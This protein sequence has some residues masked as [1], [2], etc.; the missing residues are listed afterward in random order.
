MFNMSLKICGSHA[1]LQPVLMFP[2]VNREDG[3]SPMLT[4]GV[5]VTHLFIYRHWRF[6]LLLQ[7]IF[8]GLWEQQAAALAAHS[9]AT[10]VKTPVK[11][12]PTDTAAPPES[13][14]RQF[15]PGRGARSSS[16]SVTEQ[17]IQRSQS[18]QRSVGFPG[19][20]QLSAH[21]TT[22]SHQLVWSYPNLRW[23]SEAQ[24]SKC[25]RRCCSIQTEKSTIFLVFGEFGF[26]ASTW[27]P[28]MIIWL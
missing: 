27:C 3:N 22:W 23:S 4:A 1:G 10:A 14:A 20:L 24:T 26:R 28:M 6:H 5:Q 9:S 2:D 8:F 12:C 7:N 18:T 17:S 21:W 16:Q 11:T 15:R 13:Q 25:C 19:K